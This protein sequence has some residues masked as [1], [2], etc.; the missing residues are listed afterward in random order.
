[1]NFKDNLKRCR[2]MANLTQPQ[3]AELMGWTEPS[4]ISHYETGNR[5]PSIPELIRLADVLGVNVGT[6]ITGDQFMLAQ[7]VANYASNDK[8]S[9]I[10]LISFVKAGNFVEIIEDYD[11]EMHLTTA[12]TKTRTFATRVEG[13]SMLPEFPPG[14]IVVVEPDRAAINGDYVIARNGNN[15]ATLKQLIKDGADWYLK[16]LND[17]YPIK[18]I[19][20]PEI[21]I[22][23]VVIQSS[24]N[25]K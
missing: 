8:L 4:R 16:P 15:E 13:D 6:L 24:I 14:R 1:M 21:D 25:Y 11:G 7:S 12:K 22:I 19:D 2:K 5:S 3:L 23:G 9:R 17:R 20:N 18:R 10:P